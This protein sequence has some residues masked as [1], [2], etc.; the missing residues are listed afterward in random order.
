VRSI[1]IIDDHQ[2]AASTLRDLLELRGYEVCVALDGAAALFAAQE[3][4]PEAVLLEVGIRGRVSGY[5]V[6]RSLRREVW[7]K[8]TLIIVV[9]A[10]GRAEDRANAQD[11]GCDHYLLKPVEMDTLDTLLRGTDRR[12]NSF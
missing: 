1:L 5:E 12:G 8:A 11:A 9:T 4:R 7:G 3:Q 10:W 2:D 6:C